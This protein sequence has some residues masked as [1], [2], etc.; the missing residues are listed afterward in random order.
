[1]FSGGGVAVLNGC[2]RR[3]SDGVQCPFRVIALG[4]SLVGVPTG[5]AGW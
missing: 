3:F 4:A 5:T 2:W 1:M